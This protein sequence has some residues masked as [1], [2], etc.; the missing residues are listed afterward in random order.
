MPIRLSL[1]S[2]STISY[3]NDFVR[4]SSSATG[5]TSACA[6]SRTVRRISSWSGERSKSIA[7][8]ASDVRAGEVD[9]QPHAVAGGALADVLAFELP[10]G[11]GD[12]E[13]R[14]GDVADEVR[15]ERAAH[16]APRLARLGCVVE[17]GVGALDQL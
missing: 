5:A 10:G 2:F 14:P 8:V 7:G 3:G 1:P 11:S 16:D 9:E 6:N 15:E 12:V 17:V 4:S 13:V